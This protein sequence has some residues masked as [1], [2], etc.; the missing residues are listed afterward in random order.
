MDLTPLC[1]C[2]W[3]LISSVLAEDWTRVHT[4]D[5]L[6]RS[7]FGRYSKWTRPARNI[8]DVVIVKFGLS[9]A[10]LIDVDEKNQMMTTNVWLK[11]VGKR[12]TCH[13]GRKIRKIQVLKKHI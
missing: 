6:F 10:Q 9:I 8:S 2:C 5:E 13:C 3:I 7:L 4:E 11:Q 1:C 12:L